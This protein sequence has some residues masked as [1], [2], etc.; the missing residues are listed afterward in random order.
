MSLKGLLKRIKRAF[1]RTQSAEVPT[2][3]APHY[4]AAHQATLQITAADPLIISNLLG[5]GGEAQ[6]S[7]GGGENCNWNLY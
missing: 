1:K 3:A 4:M 5:W 7:A 6:G 2:S